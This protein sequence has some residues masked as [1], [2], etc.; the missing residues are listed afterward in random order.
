MIIEAITRVR[1]KRPFAPALAVVLGAPAIL[2]CHR[3]VTLQFNVSQTETAFSCERQQGEGKENCRQMA[4][5]NVP[6]GQESGTIYIALPKG[7]KGKYHQ[8]HIHD[9]DSAR[10]VA[11]VICGAA[12]QAEPGE[13]R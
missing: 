10:P 8:V 4:S 2:G 5:N 7:C 1:R 12:E 11:Y 13:T 3:H 9:A 6:Y